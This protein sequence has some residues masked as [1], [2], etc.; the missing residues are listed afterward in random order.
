M[1]VKTAP[2]VLVKM[3]KKPKGAKWAK[4]ARIT[5]RL[6]HESDGQGY[7]DTGFTHVFLISSEGSGI[8]QLTSGEFN[9]R[10]LCHGQMIIQKYTSLL[11]DLIPGS[12]TLEI[13]SYTQLI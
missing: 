4:T 9:H 10:G 12:M 11:I 13:A 7:I 3:P 2:P 6:Y 8:A 1:K 5:D